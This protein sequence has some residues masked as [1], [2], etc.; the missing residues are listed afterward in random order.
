MFYYMSP[1][2]NPLQNEL[3]FDMLLFTFRGLKLKFKLKILSNGFLIWIIW[4]SYEWG[5]KKLTMIVMALNE[6]T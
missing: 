3:L 5:K 1:F 6:K 2:D 4:H